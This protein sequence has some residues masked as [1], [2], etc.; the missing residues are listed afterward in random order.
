MQADMIDDDL[1]VMER[2]IMVAVKNG[3]LPVDTLEK[4]EID[5][6]PPVIVS[7]DRLKE[8]QADEILNRNQVM[9]RKTW[10]TRDDLDPDAE[11]DQIEQE[12]DE[13][14]AYSLSDVGPDGLNPDDPSQWLN[15]GGK[16]P[17]NL[18]PTKTTTESEDFGDEGKEEAAR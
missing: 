18:P 2:A 12:R 1:E 15:P 13:D 3:R 9:S 17:P 16:K 11:A 5:A 14:A 10:R 6:E 8:T 4:V 7:R